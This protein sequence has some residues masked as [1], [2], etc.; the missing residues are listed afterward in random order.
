M[1]ALA[2][3]YS[4]MKRDRK[5]AMVWYRKAAEKG[6][7]NAAEILRRER[8]VLSEFLVI[9]FLQF[10]AALLFHGVV[11]PAS[12]T[13]SSILF[14]LGMLIEIGLFSLYVYLAEK[15]EPRRTDPAKLFYPLYS[16]VSML[17]CIFSIVS[18][19]V[20]IAVS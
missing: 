4:E 12:E 8:V 5:Q 2:N 19:A 3:T 9:L 17:I 11:F 20:A 7:K 16:I 18:F 14:L 10:L 13:E 15:K 1:V 6:D